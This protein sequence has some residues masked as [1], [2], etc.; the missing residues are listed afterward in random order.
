MTDIVESVRW[1]RNARGEKVD[2][3]LLLLEVRVSV[4]LGLTGTNG[5][6]LSEIFIRIVRSGLNLTPVKLDIHYL[7]VL[8]SRTLDRYKRVSVAERRKRSN[9]FTNLVP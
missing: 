5:K 1:R 4:R 6:G 9:N 3:L 7:S 2:I 8:E